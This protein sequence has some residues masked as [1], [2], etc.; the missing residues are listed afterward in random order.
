MTELVALKAAWEVRAGWT[1]GRPMP[2]YTKRWIYTSDDYEQDGA[3]AKDLAYQP[4]FMKRMAE[5]SSYH[6]QMSNPQALNWAD[7]TFIW[8]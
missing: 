6:Q 7:L 1:P 4:I 3:H 5:A 2:E 8:Y